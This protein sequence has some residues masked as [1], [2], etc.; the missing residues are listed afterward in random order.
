MIYPFILK[1]FLFLAQTENHCIYLFYCCLHKFL[2][3]GNNICHT[4]IEQINF[5]MTKQ[6]N[7]E[8]REMED[9]EL[10]TLDAI[11]R[12]QKEKVQKFFGKAERLFVKGNS[13]T[14]SLIANKFIFPLSQ[15]L[16]MNY[17]WG[18]E[19][20]NLFPHHLKAAYCRQINS[21]EIHQHSKKHLQ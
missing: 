9:L 18:R 8:V 10:E 14:R 1:G 7:M 2:R 16:E 3:L 19:Y 5:S 15:L 12:G 13:C 20:L 4:G 11:F 21:S 6:Q 17:S